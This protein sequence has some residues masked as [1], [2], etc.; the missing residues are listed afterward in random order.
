MP[1]KLIVR[2]E[3]FYACGVCGLVYEAKELAS[4]C[5]EHCRTYRT[6]NLKLAQ[7]SVGKVELAERG[8]GLRS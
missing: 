5:E 2:G 4:Q 8:L 3:V 7:S 1:L 6:C